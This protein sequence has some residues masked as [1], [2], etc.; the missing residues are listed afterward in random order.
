MAEQIKKSQSKK[1]N[2]IMGETIEQSTIRIQVAVLVTVII[3]IITAA[4]WAGT[5]F[6]QINGEIDNL[7]IGEDHITQQ[8]QQDYTEAN[9][10]IS[11][12]EKDNIELKIRLVRMETQLSNIEALLL[13]L[14]QDVKNHDEAIPK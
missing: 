4:F 7:H 6:Q 11:A 13:E 12:I 1:R 9:E 8:H 2:L 10:R 14:K 3:A 5:N